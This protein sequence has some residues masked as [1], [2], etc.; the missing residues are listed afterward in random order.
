MKTITMTEAQT[1]A[2]DA[3]DMTVIR[4]IAEEAQALA[5]KTGEPV[6]V[7]TDDGVVAMAKE[8]EA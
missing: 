5:N 8:P 1:E 4:D 2:Y 7:Y 6:E 3:D